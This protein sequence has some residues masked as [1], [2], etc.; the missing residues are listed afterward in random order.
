MLKSADVKIPINQGNK[1]TMPRSKRYY[2]W[3]LII[4]PV[5]ILGILFFIYI[6]EILAILLVVLPIIFSFTNVF[7]EDKHFQR[8][9]ARLFMRANK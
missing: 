1:E 7:L 2:L 4:I 5:I 3:L 9:F 8:F 6:P